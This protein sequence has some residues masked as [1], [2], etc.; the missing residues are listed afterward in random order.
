MRLCCVVALWIAHA[1]PAWACSLAAVSNDDGAWFGQNEDHVGPGL[2]WFVPGTKRRLGRVNVGFDG[3]FAQGA[4]NE[5]GLAFDAAVVPPV[6]WQARE[7]VR[8]VKNLP[9]LV[10]DTCRDVACAVDHFERFDSPHLAAS[11]FLF[12][13]ASG[14]AVVIAWQ[15]ERGV[16]VTR[17]TA[18]TLVA[19]NTTLEPATYRCARHVRL[20]RELAGE[21][22]APERLARG[23]EAVLQHGP[24]AFTSYTTVY[25]LKARVVVVYPLGNFSNALR[26]ELDTELGKGRK[27]HRLGDLGAEAE[28][29]IELIEAPQRVTYGTRVTLSDEVL[30]RFAGRYAV[31]G[32]D[33]PPVTVRVGD[34]GLWVSNPG[35]PDAFLFPENETQFRLAPDRGQVSFELGPDGQVVALVLHKQRDVRAARLP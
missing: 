15:P 4:M 20:S 2:I 31:D 35:S 21:G 29:L 16:V 8:S 22:A 11:Q 25:D 28:R 14:D 24:G 9:D 33:V 19:T 34:G 30:A 23:L 3:V 5:A 32:A 26:F 6:A 1:S 27:K 17:S 10:L 18:G 13:D 7:G 12:A